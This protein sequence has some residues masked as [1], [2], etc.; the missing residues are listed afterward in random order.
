MTGARALLAVCAGLAVAAAALWAA[1][2]LPWVLVRSAGRPA[3]ELTGAV[4]VPA[5]TG[6]ALVALAGIAGIVATAGLVRRVLGW[7]LAAA[8]LA[9]VTTTVPVVFGD[10]LAGVPPEDLPG[11]ARA[12]E[13]TAAPLLAAAAAVVLVAV[14]LAVAAREPRLPRLG[15]RYSATARSRAGQDPDRRAWQD[16]DDGRDPTV[17]ADPERDPGRG[18]DS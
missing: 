8:A 18:D 6:I 2:A 5:L 16:L 9:V 3:L 10:P 7:L 4:L 12:V 15:A 13:L 17:G 1:A 14:G 11:G